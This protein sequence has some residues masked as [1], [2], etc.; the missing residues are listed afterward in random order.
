[1]FDAD[2]SGSIDFTEFCDMLVAMSETAEMGAALPLAS[3]SGGP[4]IDVED[5]PDEDVRGG[6][7]AELPEWYSEPD[8][9]VEWCGDRLHG[10]FQAGRSQ[11][12]VV[13]QL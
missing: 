10:S 7:A 11:G 5:E 3:D 8:D 13:S 1:M 6:G 4:L 9:L 12:R 2:A